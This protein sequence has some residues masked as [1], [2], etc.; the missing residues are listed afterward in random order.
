[1]DKQEANFLLDRIKASREYTDVR[2]ERLINEDLDKWYIDFNRKVANSNDINKLHEL[3][4][5]LSIFESTA[6]IHRENT[7]L[8]L[9][10]QLNINN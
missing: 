10:E 4:K 1:M 3:L 9:Y 2:K 5:E 6:K 7:L 8:F